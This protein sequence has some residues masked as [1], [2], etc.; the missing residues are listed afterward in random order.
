MIPHIH[1]ICILNMVCTGRDAETKQGRQVI[2]R[3]DT[4]VNTR[5]VNQLTCSNLGQIERPLRNVIRVRNRRKQRVGLVNVFGR[6][7][8]FNIIGP[9]PQPW[10]VAGT[11]K[12][13]LFAAL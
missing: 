3:P 4:G 5:A 11:D 10:T 12:H 6:R 13:I 1:V 9:I 7:V 2:R 8:V